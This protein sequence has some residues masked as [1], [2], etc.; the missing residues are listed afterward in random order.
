MRGGER[1]GIVVAEDVSAK[2]SLG[3][4]FGFEGVDSFGDLG[5]LVGVFFTTYVHGVS[6]ALHLKG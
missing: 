5:L 4:S 6:S 3:S 1:G 2:G